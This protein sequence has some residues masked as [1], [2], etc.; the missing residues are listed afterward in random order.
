MELEYAIVHDLRKEVGLAPTVNPRQA[1]LG[2]SE[3]LSN[4]FQSLHGLYKKKATKGFGRFDTDTETFRFSTHLNNFLD[5]GTGQSFIDFTLTSL[6]IL[7]DR[8]STE[9]LARGGYVL[10]ISYKEEEE[11]FVFITV[12]RQTIGCVITDTLDIDEA[13]HLEMDKLHTGCQIDIAKWQNNPT[14]QYITFIKGRGTET[15]PQYFLKA[16]GCDEFANSAH[17]TQELIRAVSDY[18]T[19]QNYSSEQKQVL[20]QKVYD[21]CEGRDN[22]KLDSLSQTISDEEPQKFLEFL[23]E[24]DY[25]VGNGF[26]PHKQHLTKLREIKATGE[27]IQL[28]FPAAMLGNRIT[29]DEQRNRVMINDP[30][31]NILKAL[32]DAS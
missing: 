1:L 15:T 14:E 2:E 4:L 16:I 10:F 19:A 17:Q 24:G 20:R 3:S 9:N 25:K 32:R 7:K 28:K 5:E 23:N 31:E 22:I 13:K 29:L 27:G 12:L 21:Y 26:E 11:S 8:I 18:A 6:N 30:P